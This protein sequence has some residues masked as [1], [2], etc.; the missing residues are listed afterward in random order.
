MK[1][2]CKPH[3]AFPLRPLVA[4]LIAGLGLQAHAGDSTALGTV[5]VTGS[6]TATDSY[7][8]PYSIDA[9]SGDDITRGQLGV[10]ASESLVSV[11]G[12]VVQNRQNY[13]QDLQISVRGFGA[14][15]AFGVRGV[16][17]LMDGI[18]ATNPD[19]Q[20]QVATFNLDMAERIEVLRGPFATIYGNHAGGVIQ[21]FT[22][23]PA[24]QPQVNGRFIGGSFGTWKAGIGAEG[25]SNGIGYLLDLSRF[26]T[27]G[28]RDHSKA[29][30]NQQFAKLVVHPDDVSKLTIEASGLRQHGTEDPK[31]VKLET[32]KADPHAVEDAA[33]T[34]DTRKNID[35][36]QAGGTYERRFGANK[37]EVTAYAGQRSVMQMLSIPKFKQNIVTNPGSSGGVVDFDRDFAGVGARWIQNVELGDDLLT[38][39]G[40]V[41][42]D[43]SQDDRRGYEN[44]IGSTLGVVGNLR[45]DEV[46][47][48]TSID[49]YIQA[50]YEMG[51]W[52]FTGGLRHSRVRFEVDDKYLANGDDSGSRTYNRTTPALGVLYRVTDAFHVYASA[53]TGF[54]TP[55][56]GEVS[57]KDGGGLNLGLKAAKSK[58]Y[59]VGAKA[60]LAAKTRLNVALF[61]IET[62]DEVVVKTAS[63]GRTFY[64]NAG[65]TLRQGIEIA[66]D[67]QL[68]DSLSARGSFTHM[69]AIYDE[70]FVS[71]GTT[72]PEGKRIPG[73]PATTVY[74]ELAYKHAP[75]GVTTALEGI[76]RSRVQVHDLNT[77]KPA[78]GY[79][80]FN[81]RVTAEQKSGDW[82]LGQMLRVDNLGDRKHIGSVVVGDAFK[83]YYEPGPGIAWY[84]GVNAKYDF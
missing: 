42:Y 48:L 68:T 5:V 43:W 76:Y 69:R 60:R 53:S 8:L 31:A 22:R 55:T 25:T 16:K 83:N 30:R 13:A 18:P 20:G 47:T 3:T 46:D 32:Y 24:E 15:S 4:C 35:H 81:L 49:P 59:E 65:S 72:V 45:R 6:R 39:T 80:L 14:R 17:L 27:D 62:E 58:Q 10:N 23:D 56:F 57:Y 79:A 36:Q 2:R 70:A 82:T 51:A 75:S 73:I 52:T 63:E 12:L 21:L 34:Y 50:S 74:G 71:N 44:F 40:G 78:P 38:V 64:Q 77:D 37:L 9:V 11:P 41:D 26:Q 28:F 29:S 67:S 66:L 54:E 7:E 61:Q 84:A 33:L 19:G 1:H